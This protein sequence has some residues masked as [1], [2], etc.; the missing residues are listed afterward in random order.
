MRGYKKNNPANAFVSKK[1]GRIRLQLHPLFVAVGIVYSF[2][3]DLPLFLLS[4]LVALQ[5]ECA[6]A[7]AA[8]KLGYALNKIVLT[9]FGAV[10]DGDLKHISLKDESLVAIC[11]PL[12]NL[13]TA[14][15]FAAIWWFEPTMY[16]FTDT[17]YY[18]SLTIATINLL[19]AYPLDGGRIFKC[20]LENH[21]G[22]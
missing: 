3:G 15:F 17:A 9:P 7:F 14:F 6:H 20:F 5:H 10:I 22:F 12:C 19:P 4:G 8:A 21:R 2:T 16:A 13:A 18:A 1:Q 11:G